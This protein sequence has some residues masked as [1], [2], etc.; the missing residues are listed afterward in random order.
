MWKW[1]VG[2][3]LLLVYTIGIKGII[4]REVY[5]KADE[6]YLKEYK[7]TVR[8]QAYYNTLILWINAKISGINIASYFEGTDKIAVYGMGKIGRLLCKDLLAHERDVVCGIDKNISGIDGETKVKVYLCSGKLPDID[9]V[10]ISTAYLAD[11]IVPLLEGRG[12][13]KIVTIEEVL[14]AVCG[15]MK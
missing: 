11:D 12:N 5:K 13:Y 8:L 3:V 14:N 15:G 1:I 2:I 4:T 9:Y 6:Q 10:V 7:R